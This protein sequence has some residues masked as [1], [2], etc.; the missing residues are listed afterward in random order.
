IHHAV[1]TSAALGF[2]IAAASVIGYV[3]SGYQMTGLPTGSLGYVYLPALA[4]IAIASV[5]TAPL[6]ART[7]HRMEVRK[8][9]R[10]FAG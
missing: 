2:P 5:L 10:I 1:A 9:K 8:L 3:W 7:A 6:G 4:V